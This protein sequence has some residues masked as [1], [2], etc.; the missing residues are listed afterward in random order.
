[1]PEPEVAPP[2]SP[3][4]KSIDELPS[5]F[6]L[7]ADAASIRAQQVQRLKL[8]R[9][10]RGASAAERQRSSRDHVMLGKVRGSASILTR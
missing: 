6:D 5:S 10:Q 7:L 1:M 4:S 2:L 9:A 8:R 3:T